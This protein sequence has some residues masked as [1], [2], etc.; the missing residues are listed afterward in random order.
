[1]R[2]MRVTMALLLGCVVGA[3]CTAVPDP[4]GFDAFSNRRASLS[5]TFC[6][7]YARETGRSAYQT[8]RNA[9]DGANAFAA[10]RANQ[11]ADRAFARCRA[12]RTN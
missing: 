12:G 8:A 5:E 2:A 9:S 7:R 3:G 6:D 10:Q 4:S 11:T 1:M